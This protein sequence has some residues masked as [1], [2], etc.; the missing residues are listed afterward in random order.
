[1]LKCRPPGNRHPRPDEI[2][3]CRP[4]LEQQ[5]EMI[6]PKVIVTLGNFATKLLLDTKDGITKVRGK[7]Y[8]Y[9]DA[10][11][12]PTFHPSAALQGGGSDVIVKMR[13]DL[14]R[15]KLALAAA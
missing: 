12:V 6:D 8:R 10:Q 3:S 11:L 15:A 4:F 7:L 9:R 1:M 2:S 5:I 13:A 14:V